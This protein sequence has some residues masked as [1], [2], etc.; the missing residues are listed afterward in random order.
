VAVLGDEDVALNKPDPEML[1][2]AIGKM[3]LPGAEVIMVG[4]SLIDIEAAKNAGVRVF[5]VPSGATPRTD[6]EKGQPT[7]ILDTLM[8]LLKYL[9]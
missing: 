9:G 5:S 3:A 2:T 6:L 7:A 4:D 1:L 8:D